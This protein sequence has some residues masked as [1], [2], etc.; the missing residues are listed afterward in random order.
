MKALELVDHNKFEYKDVPAPGIQPDE[1]LIRVRAVGICGSDVHGQDGSTGRRIPPIIMGHEASGEVE[2][3]G[4]DVSGFSVGERVTFDSTL[5]CGECFYCRRGEINFCEKRRV[6]GV[7]A[8]EYSQQGAFAEFV[9]VPARGVYRIPDEVSY[10]HAAMVEPLSIAVHAASI[11]PHQIG[12]SAVVV[13]AGMIGLLLIQVLRI[14]GYGNILAVDIDD[15]KLKGASSLGADFV[16]NSKNQELRPVVDE[17]S[18]GRGTACAFDAVG[19][20]ASFDSAVRSVRRGGTV[21]VIGNIARTIEVPLQ[22]IVT[23][24]IRVQG[25]NASAG[26]YPGCLEMLRHNAVDLDS[27]ISAVRPLEEGADWFKRLYHNT[28]GLLKVIL[29]P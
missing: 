16:V 14:T 17:M 29:K 13:G 15:A 28:E 19:V 8:E 5:Y 24:Q 11:T 26:E 27:L 25:S 20:H 6:L 2:A 10:E 9:S 3:I 22:R 7:S 18:S 23:T 21:T 12:D 1:L 4:E